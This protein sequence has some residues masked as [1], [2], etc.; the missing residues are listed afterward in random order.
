MEKDDDL[1]EKIILDIENCSSQKIEK[2]T[3]EE[4]FELSPDP[5]LIA[6]LSGGVGTF[7]VRSLLHQ[8]NIDEHHVFRWRLENKY[9]Q[10]RILTYYVP[11]CMAETI[12]FSKL[13]DEHDGVKKI[14]DLCANGFFVKGTLGD[15]SGRG[16]SFDRTAEVDDI[17]SLHQP[18]DDHQE[19]WVLQKRLNFEKEFR[20]HTFSKDLIRG[21]TIEMQG[22]YLSNSYDAEEFVIKLLQKLPDTIL[23]GTLIGW[24]IGLT[25]TNEYYVIEANITGYHP[26]Y[27]H[28]FQTSGYFGDR[29]YG[30]II[31][32]WLN[33]YFKYN[34]QISIDS[35]E[36]SLLSNYP[37]YKD[38]M[39][40]VS[41]FN[42]DHM[43]IIEENRKVPAII[44]LGEDSN[45]RL[46]TL[47]EYFQIANFCKNY[48]L[49]VS[50]DSL[51]TI[52]DKFSANGFVN[53]LAEK[54]LFTTKQYALIRQL[55]DERRRKICYAHAIRIIRE[56]TFFI[57]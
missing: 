48:Y 25:D 6:N 19:K 16:N 12:S 39:F 42:N 2:K 3:S 35:V 46:I 45:A 56:N 51:S 40:Y 14:K 36:G 31:C 11:N 5:N 7:I 30:A 26:E 57:I 55:T 29:N 34:Y 37:F 10:Y 17:I 15:G 21:L 4:T 22:Q 44:Y 49:I 43:E 18:D 1:F 24:D 9:W 13:L 32:A 23:Q 52:T 41:V 20:I 50:E 47:I 53:I 28:G 8:L 38:F 27:G 54:S 33:N